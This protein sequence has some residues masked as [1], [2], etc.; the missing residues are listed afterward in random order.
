[1]RID[2]VVYYQI[3]DPKLYAY[4]VDNPIMAIE[5]LAKLKGIELPLSTHGIEYVNE[6]F[7]HDARL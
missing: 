2:T 3:T 7:V 6:Y 5:N 1:M 4:G